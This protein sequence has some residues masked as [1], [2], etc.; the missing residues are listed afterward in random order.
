MYGEIGRTILERRR[1]ERW[2]TKVI[3]RIATELRTEFPQQRGL[4]TRDLQY[5]QQMA[6]IWPDSLAQQP[7]GQVPWGHVVLIMGRCATRFERDSYA[8]HAVRAVSTYAGLPE[9]VRELLP[10]AEDLSRIADHVLNATPPP[11]DALTAP[12]PEA[13]HR[14]GPAPAQSATARGTA[15]PP[16]PRRTRPSPYARRHDD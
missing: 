3:E 2:G 5:M 7:V 13:A 10:S 4:S 6:R 1:G 11:E 12:P 8:R 16:R 15:T 9:G 14:P